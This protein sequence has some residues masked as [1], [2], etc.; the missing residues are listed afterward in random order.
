[1]ADQPFE[2]VAQLHGIVH[3]ELKREAGETDHRF[4][5]RQCPDAHTPRAAHGI[6][7]AEETEHTQRDRCVQPCRRRI[8]RDE[9]L[10]R[11][12]RHRRMGLGRS[13]ERAGGVGPQPHRAV[14]RHGEE[15]R[16]E[17]GSSMSASSVMSGDPARASAADS[18]DF[19]TPVPPANPIA[20]DGVATALACSTK[21]SVRDRAS[22]KTWLRNRCRMRLARSR[23][24]LPRTRRCGA[25]ATGGRW[26][27]VKSG[28]R[29][30]R[31]RV[32]TTASGG[33]SRRSS[34]G[35]SLRAAAGAARH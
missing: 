2:A 10:V 15:S 23:V 31:D 8:D 25:Q 12:R 1:M 32:R 24:P 22:G 26:R 17:A 19:P 28:G 5:R 13:E 30:R 33:R 21:R 29:S 34:S 7:R 9:S 27:S 18:V 16:F 4:A 14:H 20:P 3:V 6:A 11:I 35:T